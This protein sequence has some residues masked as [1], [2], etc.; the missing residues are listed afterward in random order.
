MNDA[1]P[2][3]GAVGRQWHSTKGSSRFNGRDPRMSPVGESRPMSPADDVSDL[4]ED[5]TVEIGEATVAT[6]SSAHRQRASV[7]DMARLE[8]SPPREAHI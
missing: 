5:E 1:T 4:D 6:T 2:D 7:I 8:G 3:T